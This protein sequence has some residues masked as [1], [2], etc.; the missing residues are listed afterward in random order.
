[1]LACYTIFITSNLL[2]LSN[3]IGISTS[4]CKSLNWSC[5]LENLVDRS[6]LEMD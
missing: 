6:V 5:I 3:E 2:L 1:M 4:F